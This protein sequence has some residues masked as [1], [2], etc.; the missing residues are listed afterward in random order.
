MA[1]IRRNDI[2]LLFLVVAAIYLY[3]ENLGQFLRFASQSSNNDSENNSEK[4][5]ENN[6]SEN[7]SENND[8]DN[9]ETEIHLTRKLLS[10][11]DDAFEDLPESIPGLKLVQSRMHTNDEE[12]SKEP[13]LGTK[14]RFRNLRHKRNTPINDNYA[15]KLHLNVTKHGDI[16]DMSVLAEDDLQTRTKNRK[17]NYLDMALYLEGGERDDSYEELHQAWDSLGPFLKTLYKKNIND[18]NK[19]PDNVDTEVVITEEPTE[20]SRSMQTVEKGREPKFLFGLLNFGG[21]SENPPFEGSGSSLEKEVSTHDNNIPIV[22]TNVNAGNVMNSTV[23]P[24]DANSPT[25]MELLGTSELVSKESTIIKTGF[26]GEL[27]LTEDLSN[28][29]FQTDMTTIEVEPLGKPELVSK[30]STII[31]T[32]FEGELNLTED[33]SNSNFQTDMPKTEVEPLGKPELVSKE[34]TI[35]KTAFEGELNLTEDLSN[36][37]FQ[38]DIPTTVVESFSVPE[39]IFKVV[40]VTH[41]IPDPISNE[42]KF[43]RSS[44]ENELDLTT[45]LKLNPRIG[46]IPETESFIVESTTLVP[47]NEKFD[48]S[49]DLNSDSSLKSSTELAERTSPFDSPFAATTIKPESPFTSEQLREFCVRLMGGIGKSSRSV[50]ESSK[51]DGSGDLDSLEEKDKISTDVPSVRPEVSTE[52]TVKPNSQRVGLFANLWNRLTGGRFRRLNHDID[53]NMDTGEDSSISEEK[54]IFQ[55]L[56]S[57]E[58]GSN[59]NVENLV[60]EDDSVLTVSDCETF[61]NVMKRDAIFTKPNLLDILINPHL[62]NID[63]D[64]FNFTE[65]KD[66]QMRFLS[67]GPD[68]EETVIEAITLLPISEKELRNFHLSSTEVA[69]DQ[70]SDEF[71]IQKEE[72]TESSNKIFKDSFSDSPLTSSDVAS[73]IAQESFDSGTMDKSKIKNLMK[74]NE[75]SETSFTERSSTLLNEQIST[76]VTSEIKKSLSQSNLDIITERL[77]EA[78]TKM[79]SRIF[80]W[81]NLG[82]GNA[83]IQELDKLSTQKMDEIEEASFH[84]DLINFGSGDGE[85]TDRFSIDEQHTTTDSNIEP[86][87]L[88]GIFEFEN[89]ISEREVTTKPKDPPIKEFSTL[90][91]SM[92]KSDEDIIK[93]F[94]EQEHPSENEHVVQEKNTEIRLVSEDQTSSIDTVNDEELNRRFIGL[95]NF[96]GSG[97]G[98]ALIEEPDHGNCSDVALPPFPVYD[99]GSQS[100]S[101]F[102]ET[103]LLVGPLTNEIISNVSI[104]EKDRHDLEEYY[105]N[106]FTQTQSDN[107]ED[108]SKMKST[109]ASK[110]DPNYDFYQEHEDSDVKIHLKETMEHTESI[111]EDSDVKIHLKETMEHTESIFEDSDVK[112]HLKETMGHTE[113]ISEDSDVKIHLKETM[114]HTESISEDSDVKIHL[115]ETMG[116]TESISEDSDVKIHLKETMEHTES[117]SE[118]SDVKIHLKETMEHTESI[119]EDSDVK[120]HL[121]ETMEHTESISEDSDV[122]IHLKETMEHT[123]SISEDSDVKIHLKETMKHTESISESSTTTRTETVIPEERSFIGNLFLGSGAGGLFDD[124]SEINLVEEIEKTTFSPVPSPGRRGARFHDEWPIELF[125]IDATATQKETLP[126]PVSPDSR[127][128]SR[129]D[130]LPFEVRPAEQVEQTDN[131]VQTQDVSDVFNE[132]PPSSKDET[133]TPSRKE[134]TDDGNEPGQMFEQASSE[135]TSISETRKLFKNVEE[136]T[137]TDGIFSTLS[138]TPFNFDGR[139]KTTASVIRYCSSAKECDNRL[140]ERCVTLEGQGV[141]EC[142][143]AFIRHPRTRVCEAP[144]VLRTSLKLPGEVFHRDLKDPSS[145]RFKKMSKDAIATMWV[146]LQENPT[147]YSSVA[148]VDVSGF[149][150]GSLVV[151][152][153]LV[154]VANDNESISEVVQLVDEDI[155]EAFKD[156]ELLKKAPLNVENAM[157]LSVSNDVN[158]CEKKELNY[159]SK[160][161]ECIRDDHRGFKCRCKEGYQDY[162]RNRMY[163]GEICVA[164]CPDYCGDNGYCEL[165]GNGQKQCLC[166]GWYFGEKCEISGILV[167]SGFAA[168][169]VVIIIVVLG[170]VCLCRRRRRQA[171]FY[172]NNQVMFN[173]DHELN[174]FGPVSPRVTNTIALDEG[175]PA[176]SSKYRSISTP[177]HPNPSIQIISPS[178]GSSLSYDY[179]S[180]F[181]RTPSV[182]V[183]MEPPKYDSVP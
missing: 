92:S 145:H 115:K 79:D 111:S 134:I 19:I 105:Y 130:D 169:N 2:I 45:D 72:I 7:A 148:S 15:W 122:K 71:L 107:I 61:F 60:T 150:K 3:A 156:E 22:V 129:L 161:A 5:S 82:S 123:E 40:G 75:N 52:V 177:L 51:F 94:E 139:P 54:G 160:D 70:F 11:E 113:S 147:L 88:G 67:E 118:D 164:T 109:L 25:R 56:S 96:F 132:T 143:R 14:I 159:C 101:N 180:T 179:D 90:G 121:K 48:F 26:E 170:A 112:I 183:S 87:V 81:L 181:D 97:D 63:T 110:M 44:L 28:S 119:S 126:S 41:D 172:G 127:R 151:H 117:I 86:R 124:N 6:D 49:E 178:F 31:K 65:I 84:P 59:Q 103:P 136:T 168:L 83:E 157:L 100:I 76:Q 114:G 50:D 39:P 66:E 80:G 13:I 10:H 173:P 8:S 27:N 98:R 140:N 137:V 153:E 125:E 93:A 167:I 154:L 38:T 95:P 36:A 47:T 135:Q 77:S 102:T 166:N 68:S 163:M 69:N 146:L 91:P 138:S 53:M 176:K 128:Q 142:G 58:S 9:N 144:I 162:S 20:P 16:L 99:D 42:Q 108:F 171:R 33:L 46:M 152:W 104:Y 116:H 12:A 64:E 35:I 175:G 34:S 55:G 73:S 133:L 85:L 17:D 57:T 182:A 32:G 43:T 30:E 165:R 1:R 37:N 29:N 149:E 23:A 158:P 18:L 74:E 141:C 89:D 24:L 4:A 120:I 106:E 131:P 174:N 155:Q 62:L 78:S 21:N